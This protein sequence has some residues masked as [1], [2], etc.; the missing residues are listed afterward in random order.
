MGRLDY[1][2]RA[3]LTDDGNTIVRWKNGSGTTSVR[4]TLADPSTSEDN[5]VRIASAGSEDV[6]GVF[7]ESGIAN[8]DDVWVATSGR[9]QMLLEDGVGAVRGQYL[10]TSTTAGGRV[11]A[12]SSLPSLFQRDRKVGMATESVAAGTDVLVWGAFIIR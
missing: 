2:G 10:I 6:I 12:V 8:G 1:E 9:V 4:G 7:Y 3:A 5:A 11:E